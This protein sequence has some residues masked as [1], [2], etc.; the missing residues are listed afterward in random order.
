MKRNLAIETKARLL[1][2]ITSNVDLA[3]ALRNLLKEPS[4]SLSALNRLLEAVSKASRHAMTV[5]LSLLVE[6]LHIHR[7]SALTSATGLLDQSKSLL[8]AVPL[9]A[10]TLF[11]GLVTRVAEH[12]L[13]C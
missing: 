10:T 11:G 12:D 13:H 1:V 8:R 7:D 6:L 5:C 4:M 2:C 3:L 9:S